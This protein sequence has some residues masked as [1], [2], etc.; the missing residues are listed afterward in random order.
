MIRVWLQLGRV[1]ESTLSGPNPGPRD[2]RI[3]F[4]VEAQRFGGPSAGIVHIYPRPAKHAANGGVS[5]LEGQ[6]R[7]RL[8]QIDPIHLSGDPQCPAEATRAIG[9]PQT[10]H[11]RLCGADQHG[12]WVTD[13]TRDGVE[14]P[15]HSVDQI[16]ISMSRSPEHD[17][18]SAGPPL[19]G[20]AGKILRTDIG[21]GLHDPCARFA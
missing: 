4:G 8:A 18:G 17:L 10:A 2:E 7:A 20:V 9:P 14:A 15:V 3:P 12:G 21:L 13:A 16:D 19:G 5:F 1:L 6:G 11:S